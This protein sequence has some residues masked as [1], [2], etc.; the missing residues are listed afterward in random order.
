MGSHTPHTLPKERLIGHLFVID[1]IDQEH[2]AHKKQ[3]M[4]ATVVA[5]DCYYSTAQ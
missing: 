3:I 1:K 4:A 2:T 5:E